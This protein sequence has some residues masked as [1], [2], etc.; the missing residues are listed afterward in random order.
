MLEMNAVMIL[1]LKKSAVVVLYLEE[2]TLR[3]SVVGNA[4]STVNFEI[5]I[6]GIMDFGW[7]ILDNDCWISELNKNLRCTM[8]GSCRARGLLGGVIFLTREKTYSLHTSWSFASWKK[9]V[10]LLF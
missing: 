9:A 2:E 7:T 10:A 5:I 8:L 4:G 1:P 3:N 6:A